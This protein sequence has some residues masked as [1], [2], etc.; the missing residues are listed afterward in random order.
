MLNHNMND[1][2]ENIY[3]IIT[4]IFTTLNK[5]NIIIT[6]SIPLTLLNL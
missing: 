5:I 4:I 6:I 1:L 3:Q 2:I